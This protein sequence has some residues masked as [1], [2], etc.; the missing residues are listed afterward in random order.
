M[1][2][3][4][5]NKKAVYDN[6][7]INTNLQKSY[8]EPQKPRVKQN[9][10]KVTSNQDS[11]A[12]Q[13]ESLRQAQLKAEIS[14]R[15]DMNMLDRLK[16]NRKQI[17]QELQ[18][19]L[20]EALNQRNH[21]PNVTPQHQAYIEKLYLDLRLINPELALSILTGSVEPEEPQYITTGGA[22]EAVKQRKHKSK[23]SSRHH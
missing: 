4:G 12:Y 5:W 15:N 19:K 16:D 17:E 1:R 13:K 21:M 11:A 3:D 23:S 8:L 18:A 7:R 22:E 9:L 10:F 6:Q 20:F 14:H 2:Y